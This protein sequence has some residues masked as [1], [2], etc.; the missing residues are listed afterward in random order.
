MYKNGS[1]CV[2]YIVD[3]VTESHGENRNSMWLL[4]N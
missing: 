3:I 4:I 1:K 2:L